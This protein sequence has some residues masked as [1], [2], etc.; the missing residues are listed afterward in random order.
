M[1]KFLILTFILISLF[2]LTVSAN[3]ISGEYEGFKWTRIENDVY[4]E[5]TGS[6]PK[7]IIGALRVGDDGTET[8]VKD[9]SKFDRIVLSEGITDIYG[10]TYT[11]TVNASAEIGEFVFPSTFSLLPESVVRC[12]KITV[13]ENNPYFTSRDG[14]LF[15]KDMA[16]LLIYP[17]FRPDEH[18]DVPSTVVK[19]ASSAFMF[20]QHLK[21]ISIPEGVETIE[22][23]AFYEAKKI[24]RVS[25]P[26]TLKTIGVSAFRGTNLIELSIPNGIETLPYEA[27]MNAKVTRLYLPASLKKI[28]TAAISTFNLKY[29]YYGGSEEDWNNIEIK[30]IY[31][32]YSNDFSE[33]IFTYNADGLPET[34]TPIE[35]VALNDKYPS[36]YLNDEKT[37]AWYLD[38]D[39]VLHV[40]GNGRVKGYPGSTTQLSSNNPYKPWTP[41]IGSTTAHIKGL[42]VH[43]GITY[44]GPY[45]FSHYRYDTVELPESLEFIG[46]GAFA[47]A[48][49]DKLTIRGVTILHGYSFPR[50]QF[51]QIV[52]PND[53][54]ILQL[55]CFTGAGTVKELHLPKTLKQIETNSI[56][57]SVTDIYYEGSEKDWSKISIFEDL[58]DIT[59]H[60]AIP[61]FFAD[62]PDNHWAR[63]YIKALYDKEIIGGTSPTTYEPEATL[64]W[65]QALKLL[66]VSCA[67]A[68]MSPT[69]E[70]WAS[71]FL[72]YAKFRQWVGP[73]EISDAD[74]DTKI[75]RL[76]FCQLA[77]GV[78]MVVAQ[79]E[80]NPFTDTDDVMVLAL[81]NAGVIGGTTANT[82][83]PD[84]YLTRAQI[85]KIICLLMNL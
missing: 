23:S 42:V 59:I 85:A 25:L 9:F 5:G 31:K 28:D 22:D 41:H 30:S 65:G 79:P 17:Y 2:T 21:S 26:S 49:G 32:F 46:D 68:N 24:E 34:D 66:L 11:V 50:T 33:A 58:S 38:E 64:T 13:S 77:A 84:E 83:S 82:F 53:I 35:V 69:R 80:T 19:I 61:S 40:H 39:K 27:F 16:E 73:N 45:A 63:E 55:N 60:Y 75:T 74:L 6:L 18:Y 36:G 4:I 3:T 20:T 47:E 54:S 8:D 14:V 76:R 72:D 56:P 1:K 78:K 62:V 67:K 15:S 57:N 48:M 37:T 43:E 10:L 7:K 81:Y 29:V 44:I 51:K 70:H 52:L 71:G 12:Q